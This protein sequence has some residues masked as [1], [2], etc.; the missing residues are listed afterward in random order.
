MATPERNT[1]YTLR[2]G[3][4]ILS[5][6]EL[7]NIHDELH[8]IYQQLQQY[9]IDG[10]PVDDR[11]P[12]ETLEQDNTSP[13]LIWYLTK[14]VAESQIVGN[15]S[16]N[17]LL[18]TVLTVVGMAIGNKVAISSASSDRVYF[19]EIIDIIGNV[20]TLDT[21][22][23]FGYQD[24]DYIQVGTHDLAVD[25]SV[26]T[27]KFVLRG[28]AGLTPD[29]PSTVDIT[30]IMITCLATDP[31]TLATF[32][33]LPKLLHGLVFRMVN[34][35]TNN[36]FNIKTNVEL[37]G[38][39]FDWQPYLATNPAQG[40]NGFTCRLT[41]NGQSKMGIVKRVGQGEDLEML[42]QDDLSGLLALYVTVEGHF[43]DVEIA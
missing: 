38:L 32:G 43:A 21:P 26:V 9:E 30:R 23:D 17:D 33:D 37:A 14:S 34:G 27:Q 28:A 12:I 41:F 39:S 8:A 22:L 40:Q 29:I 2:S 1:K 13:S 35:V 6:G 11:D 3:K 31:V 10:F 42:V 7:I 15:Y 18:V 20:L 5:T 19:G 4:A 36:I 16:I 25:G 24:G